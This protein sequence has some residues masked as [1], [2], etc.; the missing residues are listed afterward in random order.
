MR[1]DGRGVADTAPSAD[2]PE[3]G[4]P[5]LTVRMTARLQ[6]FPDSWEFAGSKTAAYRQ[7]GN[8][9]PPPVAQAL[10]LAV[11]KWLE[12]PPSPSTVEPPQLG[13]FSRGDD[14]SET[15]G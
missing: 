3:D 12:L 9:F 11:L 7:I 1:V 13:L 15:N 8:A 6:G 2:F 5:R 4:R 10:A 14:I